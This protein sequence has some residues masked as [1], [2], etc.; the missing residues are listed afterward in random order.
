MTAIK[1]FIRSR[2]FKTA[3][4]CLGVA[5]AALLV[6]QAGV[7]VGYR[8]ASFAYQFGNDYYRLFDRHAPSQ[9]GF[10]LRDEF[11]ASHGAV[12]KV[13]S[14]SL[15]DIVVAGPDSVEKTVLVSKDTLIRKLD[16]ALKPEDIRPGDFLTALG[17]PD[18]DSRIQARLIRIL[19]APP[20][21]QGGTSASTTPSG[22]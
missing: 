12:G 3:L 2:P 4:A 10:P 1:D 8:K 17:E 9:G 19:P 22:R 20:D 5:V 14:V 13:V 6:F 7:Y 11:R 21:G 16:A 15:P 18:K